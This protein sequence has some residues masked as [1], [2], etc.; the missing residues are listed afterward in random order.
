LLSWVLADEAQETLIQR[1]TPAGGGLWLPVTP[2]L[3]SGTQFYSDTS[4]A[5]D[6]THRY[7]LRVRSASGNLNREYNEIEV[8][9][10]TGDAS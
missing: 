1:S 8:S 7:R 5:A 2:W 10:P 9:A 4:A 6:V 3:A